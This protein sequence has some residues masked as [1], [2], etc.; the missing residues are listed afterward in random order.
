MET[1]SNHVLVGGVV[2]ALLVALLVFIVWL[3]G[4]NV[5][6]IQRYD[7]FFK[8]SVDGLAKGS[9][10]N[11]SGVPV[12][13]IEEIKLMPDSPEFVR[14]RIAVDQDTPILQG[15][16]A[17][18]AGIGFTGVSQINLDGAVK[19]AP[20]ITEPGPYGK[21]VIPTKPG[22]LGELLNSAP[23]LLNRISTLTER[24]TEL[25]NDRNQKSISG[26][27]AHV[28]KLSGD[29][30][31]RGPEIAAAIVQL[32][33]TMEQAGNAAER[34]GQLAETTNGVMAEDVKPAMANLNKAT[35]A[36]QHT[37]ET[38]DATITDARPGI[39]AFS[40]QTVPQINQLARN[41]AEMSEALGAISNKL[42]RGGAGAVLGGSK[43]PDYKPR[44]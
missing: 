3:A 8:T 11:F 26:I 16:T 31:D 37:L 7:I 12:G 14:V 15:T 21:P 9:P 33:T 5:A 42:D 1:R 6:S 24:L 34:V 35:T 20:P 36:A 4:F 43:L 29:L 39:K 32:K 2:L 13:K 38:L 41:L 27:L 17:T 23:E 28:D 22:A 40:T 19:G 10:V 44:N 30:A 25:L 18:I